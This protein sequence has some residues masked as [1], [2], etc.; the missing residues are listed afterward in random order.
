MSSSSSSSSSFGFVVEASPSGM[1]SSSPLCLFLLIHFPAASRQSP[2]RPRLPLSL[3]IPPSVVFWH[4]PRWHRAGKLAPMVRHTPV[5]RAC[6]VGGSRG[7]NSSW[8]IS[9]SRERQRGREAERQRDRETERERWRERGRV[10]LPRDVTRKTATSRPSKLISTAGLC[11]GQ[12]HTPPSHLHKRAERYRGRESDQD[13]DAG[14]NIEETNSLRLRIQWDTF[15]NDIRLRSRKKFSVA[16]L[17]FYMCTRTYIFT[18]RVLSFK[19]L[20]SCLRLF[21]VTCQWLWE[22]HSLTGLSVPNK[23]D[24]KQITIRSLPGGDRHSHSRHPLLG[25]W[26]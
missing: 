4:S 19:S 24:R 1:A 9:P 18:Y 8:P 22:F 12:L 13:K 20:F 14:N 26:R 2:K 7:V 15:T 11:T 3:Q 5:E 25:K 10:S 23:E 21:R 6:D 17:S 16:V